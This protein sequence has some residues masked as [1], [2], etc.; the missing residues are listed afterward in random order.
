[1]KAILFFLIGN[2]VALFYFSH[3]YLQLSNLAVKRRMSFLLTFPARFVVLSLI[4][5]ALLFLY[6]ASA[7]Y[8]I[9]GLISGRFLILHLASRAH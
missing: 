3:L 6:G 9:A 2:L 7:L 4:S 1:M 5:G 8:Y